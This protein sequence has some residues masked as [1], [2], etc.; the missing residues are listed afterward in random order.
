M[1]IY[2]D[3]RRLRTQVWRYE[4]DGML[5]VDFEREVASAIASC[6]F[7][8]LIDSSEARASAYVRDECR[9]ALP[10]LSRSTNPPRFLIALGEPPG[11]WRDSEL[12]SRQNKIRYVDLTAY[13]SGIRQLCLA[14]GLSYE[15]EFAMPRDADFI[16]EIHAAKLAPSVRD[17]LITQYGKFRTRYDACRLP[18]AEDT[19]RGL[20]LDCK[21]LNLPAVSPGLA[22]AVLYGDMLRDA[23]AVDAFSRV[24]VVAPKD[25]RGWGGLGSA[26]SLERR[27]L[28]ALEAYRRCIA[29]IDESNSA[30]HR[31]HRRQVLYNAAFVAGLIGRASD[32]LAFL[33]TASGDSGDTLDAAILSLR[34]QLLMRIGE[35]R[36]A[37]IALRA[38]IDLGET[39]GEVSPGLL[40][41]L[42]DCLATLGQIQDECRMLQRARRMFPADAATHRR[43]ALFKA[44]LGKLDEASRALQDAIALQPGSIQFHAELALVLRSAGRDGESREAISWCRERSARTPEDYYFLGLAHYLAGELGLAQEARRLASR[45]PVVAAWDGYDVLAASSLS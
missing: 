22:L 18:D 44:R 12:F 17:D 14:L 29:T 16:E 31:N 41:D 35:T 11:A 2:N 42:A 43:W 24:T 37:Q 40:L 25:P 1:R 7:F 4:R 20:L 5:G 36:R 21:D 8:V 9:Q 19:L 30:V 38:A 15:P 34:G 45:D 10:R 33:A 23:D 28:E 6:S 3:L 39:Q 13:E 26:L 32:G 27:Y